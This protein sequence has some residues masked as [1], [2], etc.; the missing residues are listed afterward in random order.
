MVAARMRGALALL[1]PAPQCARCRIYFLMARAAL[2]GAVLAATAHAATYTLRSDAVA[3][4]LDAYG[5]LS[6]GGAT[7]RLLF[8]YPETQRNEIVDYLFKPSYGA[9]LHLLKVEIGG[10]GQSSEGASR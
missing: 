5:A 1:A 6:G 4:R 10:D 9:S 2:A 3:R 8:Q 7:S